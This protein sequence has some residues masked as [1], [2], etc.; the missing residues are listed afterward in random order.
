MP[1]Y[2]VIIG[3]ILLFFKDL[4]KS[5]G[6]KKAP[7]K[8][9]KIFMVSIVLYL[10]YKYLKNK[11][12]ETNYQKLNNT[13]G[14]WAMRLHKALHPFL[15]VKIPL[16][17]YFDDGTDE[18]EVIAV[19]TEMGQADK[20]GS[21]SNLSEVQTA[22]KVLYGDDL[23]EALLS[24]DVLEDFENAY[25]SAVAGKLTAKKSSTV[26]SLPPTGVSI[27]NSNSLIV[28]VGEIYEAIGGKNLRETSSPYDV[29]STTK[30]GDRFRVY[31][32]KKNMIIGGKPYVVA[33]CQKT[34]L[35]VINP[36]EDY[37]LI[38]DAFTSK[39]S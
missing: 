33:F 20:A 21:D 13:A 34:Y 19:A 25:D 29:V 4:F 39:V 17:G 37:M 38:I 26:L 6:T 23:K 18:K 35:G 12:D 36:F 2:L 8:E 28:Q 5:D 9:A 11:E 15:P 3:S 22:F 30:Q 24:D 31:M 32:L 16:I 1:S 10:V 27:R 14:T 7:N